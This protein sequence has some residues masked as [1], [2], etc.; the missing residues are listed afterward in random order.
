MSKKII[1]VCAVVF[2][3]MV[4]ASALQARPGKRYDE[5]TKMCR[6][7]NEGKLGWESEPWGLGNKKFQEVCKSCHSRDNDKGAPFLHA[8]S[9]V[10]EGWNRVFAKRRV[11]CAKDGSWAGLTEEE[12]QIINDYLY[13]NAA[14]TYDPYGKESCG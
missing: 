1:A 12:L 2:L 10:S 14:W 3:T 8:K 4:F 5:R 11:K 7:I 9:F 13:R 6:I